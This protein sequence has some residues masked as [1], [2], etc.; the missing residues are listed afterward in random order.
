MGRATRGPRSGARELPPASLLSSASSIHDPALQASSGGGR[1][2][3]VTAVRPVCSG[4]CKSVARVVTFLA[5]NDPS[6]LGRRGTS[7]QVRLC[8]RCVRRLLRE[9]KP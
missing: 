5:T 1:V 2:K 3:V 6:K 8:T 7:R 9:L 4:C